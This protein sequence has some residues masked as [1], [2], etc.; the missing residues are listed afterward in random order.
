MKWDVEAQQNK[1]LKV[2]NREQQQQ[3]QQQQQQPIC[4]RN[5]LKMNPVS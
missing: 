2:E 3:Q 5:A 1:I 4:R